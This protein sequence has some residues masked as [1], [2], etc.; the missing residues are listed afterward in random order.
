MASSVACPSWARRCWELVKSAVSAVASRDCNGALVSAASA[1][2]RVSVAPVYSLGR[3]SPSGF[4][5]GLPASASSALTASRLSASLRGAKSADGQQRVDCC[6]CA[7]VIRNFGDPKELGA[8]W[9]AVRHSLWE[10]SAQNGSNPS[11]KCEENRPRA[12]DRLQFGEGPG[13]PG[14]RPPTP[15]DVAGNVRPRLPSSRPSRAQ[16]P[17]KEGSEGPERDR[18]PRATLE[19]LTA[20][21]SAPCGNFG[22]LVARGRSRFVNPHVLR[23]GTRSPLMRRMV[24]YCRAALIRLVLFGLMVAALWAFPSGAAARTCSDYSNQRDPQL[25]KDTRDA[26]SDG[27]YCESLPCPCLKPGGG[28]GGG[29]GGGSTPAK[30]KPTV[31]SPGPSISLGKRTRSSNCHIR[32]PL[33]DPRCTPGAR[34]KNAD[35]AHICK[36]G[37]A[38]TVRNV[39]EAL[40]NQVYAEY[41]ITTHSR[42]TYEVDHLVPLEL[43]GSNS[44]ANLFPEAATPRPGF[45]EKD[46]LENKAHDRVCG[47]ARPLLVTQRTI[48]EDWTVLYTAYFG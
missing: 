46:R 13:A 7:S 33:P 2:N 35:R 17:R 26:H 3:S 14:S 45:H 4:N 31:F 21:E 15:A 10:P 40:K 24:S 43:G 47:G 18:P 42:T 1:P 41:G 36:S 32:G 11:S 44:I 48:A 39:S 6:K 16:Q 29:S 20:S 12:L 28:G 37:Y 9:R 25:N 38:K 8:G 5:S 27:I 34:F 19:P 23:P 30:P 22:F